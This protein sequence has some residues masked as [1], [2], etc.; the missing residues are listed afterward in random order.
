MDD[1][2]WRLLFSTILLVIMVL[3]RPSANSQR[4]DWEPPPSP[5]PNQCPSASVDSPSL[6][7]VLVQQE[8]VVFPTQVF[9][10]PA[11]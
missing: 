3:L 11:D 1:A 7:T 8:C 2:F 9:S 4:L 10:F 6:V 5:S